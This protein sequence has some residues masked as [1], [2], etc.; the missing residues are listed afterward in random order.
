[1]SAFGGTWEVWVKRA[2][3]EVTHK[4]YVTRR[5]LVT[6]ASASFRSRPFLCFEDM[7]AVR[8]KTLRSLSAFSV[9]DEKTF[10]V[11]RGFIFWNI[12]GLASEREHALGL[13]AIFHEP[14]VLA[15]EPVA[16]RNATGP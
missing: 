6:A 10:Q 15:D 1:M 16:P 5:K 14:P 7:K 4:R 13:Y 12:A 3:N 8:Q 9:L 11:R 2:R